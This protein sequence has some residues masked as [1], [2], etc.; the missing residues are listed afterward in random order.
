[1]YGEDGAGH[2]V[3]ELRDAAIPEV[4]Y[5]VS[6]LGQG[7]TGVASGLVARSA[8]A[9]AG[10]VDFVPLP[11]LHRSVASR[12]AAPASGD[13]AESGTGSGADPSVISFLFGDSGLG[14]SAG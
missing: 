2:S 14:E 11:A 9:S 6:G 7:G 1:M 10:G 13:G 5:R 4:V 3:D 8:P 12:Q